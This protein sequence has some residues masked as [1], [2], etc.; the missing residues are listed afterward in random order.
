MSWKRTRV[1][2]LDWDFIQVNIS[3]EQARV[4]PNRLALGEDRDLVCAA[5]SDLVIETYF[6]IQSFRQPETPSY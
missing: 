6:P 3:Q 1:K 4:R 2:K 5:F